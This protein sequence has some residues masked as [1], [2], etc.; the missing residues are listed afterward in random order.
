MF[1]FILK[2]LVGSYHNG[3]RVS[4]TGKITDE[5]ARK[6]DLKFRSVGFEIHPVSGPNT[7]TVM[8]VGRLGIE[9]RP[10]S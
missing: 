8:G 4:D 1:W 2:K 7:V 6:D 3:K 10:R 9:A 5:T